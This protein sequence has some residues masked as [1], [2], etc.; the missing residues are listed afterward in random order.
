M[1]KTCVHDSTRSQER[2]ANVDDDNDDDDGL[3]GRSTP[4]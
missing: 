2:W 3:D 4:S 1:E